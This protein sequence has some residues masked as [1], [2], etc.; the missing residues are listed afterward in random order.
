M[1]AVFPLAVLKM[2]DVT[3][4]T[5][6]VGFSVVG[7]R[8][9]GPAR[10]PECQSVQQSARRSRW[11]PADPHHHLTIIDSRIEGSKDWG[12]YGLRVSYAMDGN[13]GA[14]TIGT[15]EEGPARVPECPTISK[16][17]QMVASGPL[18]PQLGHPPL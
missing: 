13:P 1:K 11:L 10:V 6:V 9:R 4:L 3:R 17:E 16:T 14:P 7:V 18:L 15:V 12:T 2:T 5:R 8:R